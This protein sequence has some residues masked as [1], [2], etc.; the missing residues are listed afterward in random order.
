MK[1]TCDLV[2]SSKTQEVLN[3]KDE[4]TGPEMEHEGGV[5]GKMGLSTMVFSSSSNTGL[6]SQSE[7]G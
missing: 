3:F 1:R 6:V 2:K 4:I 5:E 7:W